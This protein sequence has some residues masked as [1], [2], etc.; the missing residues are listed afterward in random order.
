MDV[1]V[2]H[3]Q[4]PEPKPWRRIGNAPMRPAPFV[5]APFETVEEAVND[6]EQAGHTVTAVQE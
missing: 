4:K 3:S 5:S 6:A 2:K 1:V